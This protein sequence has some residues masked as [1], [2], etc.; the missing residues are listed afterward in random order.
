MGK[1][2]QTATMPVKDC[3]T[4]E[5]AAE[6]LRISRA[7][8]FELIGKKTVPYFRVG[9]DPKFPRRALLDWMD[10]LAWNTLAEG[11]ELERVR[12]QNVAKVVAELREMRRK[13]FATG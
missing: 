13:G 1:E 6:L 4:P 12:D 11:E 3:Y 2:K 8:L 10:M 5:E 7:K 9:R